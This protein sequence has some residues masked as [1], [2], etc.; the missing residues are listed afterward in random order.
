MAGNA[1]MVTSACGSAHARA[2]RVQRQAHTHRHTQPRPT[3]Q[4]WRAG[5]RHATALLSRSK[6]ASTHAR[7]DSAHIMPSW[8]NHQARCLLCLFHSS[9]SFGVNVRALSYSIVGY[10]FGRISAH[11]KCD[12]QSARHQPGSWRQRCSMRRHTQRTYPTTPATAHA[13]MPMRVASQM[14]SG[15]GRNLPEPMLPAGESR[16][17]VAFGGRSRNRCW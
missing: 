9:T 10:H 4:R 8:P 6:I 15:S 7:L 13:A 11:T 17:E 12:A 2:P 14:R 16:G 1:D 3:A 5:P